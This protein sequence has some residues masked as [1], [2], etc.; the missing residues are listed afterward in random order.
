M[1]K[2]QIFETE[3]QFKAF[4]RDCWWLIVSLE[5]GGEGL[6]QELKKE[7]CRIMQHQ[8][9]QQQHSVWRISDWH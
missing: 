7:S 2:F 4:K 5:S 1:L 8:L 6:S 3:I 9:K